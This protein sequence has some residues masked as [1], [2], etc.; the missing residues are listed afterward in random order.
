VVFSRLGGVQVASARTLETAKFDNNPFADTDLL[1]AI[2]TVVPKK[3]AL[4]KKCNFS[5][6]PPL[7]GCFSDGTKQNAVVEQSPPAR[8]PFPDPAMLRWNDSR[9]T[10]PVVVT[11][12]WC[13]TCLNEWQLR[14]HTRRKYPKFGGLPSVSPMFQW[15]TYSVRGGKQYEEQP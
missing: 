8:G 2:E 10:D 9:R 3:N 15:I 13:E 7:A 4:L 1:A 5:A 14:R 12:I 11:P 6:Q